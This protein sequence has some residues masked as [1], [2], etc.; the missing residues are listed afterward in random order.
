MVGG[1]ENFN[2]IIRLKFLINLLSYFK[3]N[4]VAPIITPHENIA[5]AD[6]GCTAHFVKSEHIPILQNVKRTK[7]GPIAAVP[8]KSII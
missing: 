1:A 7:N 3:L 2:Q 6:S 8:D 4:S 5:K